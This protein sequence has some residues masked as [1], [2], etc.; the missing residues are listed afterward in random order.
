MKSKILGPVSKESDL[1]CPRQNIYKL[2]YKKKNVTMEAIP[3]ARLSCEV[4][5]SIMCKVDPCSFHKTSHYKGK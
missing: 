2:D 1:A 4:H 5:K 3:K